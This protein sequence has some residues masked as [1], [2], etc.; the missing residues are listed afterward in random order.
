MTTTPKFTI[1]VVDDN[2]QNRALARATLEEEDDYTVVLA[3]TGQQGV[4]QFERYRPDCVL[5]DIR[6]PGL[7]GF[8]V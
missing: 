8:A 4:E 6:M 2:E 7:D 1:L 5:L 3:A